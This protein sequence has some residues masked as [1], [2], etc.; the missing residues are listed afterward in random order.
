M[1]AIGVEAGRVDAH[2]EGK[3]IKWLIDPRLPTEEEVENHRLTHLP[4]RNWCPE[5][6]KAKR[7]ELDHICAVDKERKLSEYCFDYCFP[8]DE[9]GYK[10]TVL[11]GTER[12]TGMKFG[13]AVPTKGSS[14]KFAVD[15]ALDF[16]AEVGDM[17]G[18]III[19]NDQ[20]PSI[21]YFIKDL[22]ESR[23]SG[24]SH[25]EES[26]VKSSGSNGVVERG[27]QGVEGHIR[28]IFLALQGRMG[29]KIDAK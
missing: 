7:K 2:E 29:R 10:L 12:L 1:G 24:R 4:Y 11:V 5:C 6:V 17:D 19:K 21:Q 25:L 9:F 15:R 18:Q 20:E 14:G 26:P 13:T 22:V 16:I 8:G 23:E 27:V 28:A 3:F